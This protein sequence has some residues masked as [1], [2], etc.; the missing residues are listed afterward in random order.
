MARIDDLLRAALIEAGDKPADT[1]K[2]DEKKAYSEKI[3]ANIA[4][5]VADEL[6]E[7]GMKKARP[8]PPG[9]L[10]GSGAER[11]MSGGIGAKKVDVTWS[12]E[13][14]GLILGISIKSINFKDNRTQNFQ[15]NLT[16]R[17]GDMLI[18]AV[19][20]HRR[21]PYAVLGG[22]FIFDSGAATDDT[23]KRR[24]TLENAHTR[25]RLFT[26]R[27]DPAGRDEQYEAFYFMLLDASSQHASYKLYRVGQPRAEIEFHDLI[28][29]LVERVA[30]RN[31]DFYEYDNGELRSLT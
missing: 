7:R 29:E 15:K 1:A 17:R 3:S 19:T 11:R 5:A 26:G 12:T 16:N 24:S 2:S 28:C 22:L 13:E 30:V 21:F 9:E 14:S 4:L 20:L 10:G 25:F 18:E 23:A 27:D 6:R 31:P 8:A